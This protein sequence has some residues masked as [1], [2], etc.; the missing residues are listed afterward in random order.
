MSIIEGIMSW[1]VGPRGGLPANAAPEGIAPALRRTA[2][3]RPIV[4]LV[5]CG[6]FL[7]A[8]VVGVIALILSNLRSH[9]IEQSKQQL[10]AT[11]TVLARQTARDLQSIDLIEANL[12]EYMETLAIVTDELYARVREQFSEKELSDL[13]YAIMAINGWNRANVAFQTV[14]GSSDKA[15]GLDKSNLS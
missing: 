1:V 9:A 7:I 10:L 6:V 12:I 5:L 8:L 14:P 11:A 15:F 2:S 3:T 13:T 4:V